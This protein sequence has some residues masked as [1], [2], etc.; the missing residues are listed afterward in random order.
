MS[1]E[2]TAPKQDPANEQD[3]VEVTVTVPAHRV[4]QFERFHQRFLEMAQHWDN[5]VGNED[6][7]GPRGR[8]GRGGPGRR[9]GGHGHGRHGGRHDQP[10]DTPQDA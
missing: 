10:A 2:E 5:Q 9:C 7:R 8:R 6:L 1:N 3:T 4:A